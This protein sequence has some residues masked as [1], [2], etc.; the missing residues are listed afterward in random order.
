M[1]PF[2]FKSTVCSSWLNFI[3]LICEKGM[4]EL[5]MNNMVGV[6]INKRSYTGITDR[7]FKVKNGTKMRV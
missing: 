5:T 2:P 3:S 4:K 6:N 7:R 1:V